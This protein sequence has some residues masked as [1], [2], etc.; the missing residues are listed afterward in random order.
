MKT[1]NIKTNNNKALAHVS[2][3]LRAT[4]KHNEKSSLRTKRL[5]SRLGRLAVETEYA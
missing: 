4:A 3:R 2:R 5:A 1:N